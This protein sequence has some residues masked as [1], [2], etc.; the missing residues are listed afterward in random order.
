ML[1]AL[2]LGPRWR[3]VLFALRAEA[4]D[5]EGLAQVEREVDAVEAG[6]GVR[7][8]RPV[9]V[10]LRVDLVGE[11]VGAYRDLLLRVR[12]RVLDEALDAA[13]LGQEEE[14]R[15]LLRLRVVIAALDRPPADG[16]LRQQVA[17]PNR[18]RGGGKGGRGRGAGGR[19]SV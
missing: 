9:R 11:L 18:R 3:E 2:L 17:R 10:D 12:E 5:V 16:Q 4:V 8:V 19:L 1:A 15:R 13:A 6:G 14:P 7:R